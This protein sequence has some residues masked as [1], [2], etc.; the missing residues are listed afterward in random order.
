MIIRTV[1]WVVLG[2]IGV[3]LAG[4]AIFGTDLPSYVYSSAKSVRTAVKD[5]VPVE[6]ELTR[7]RDLL[8][9]IIPEMQAN[10][11]LIAQQEVEIA[12]LKQDI[13][14][15]QKSL[16]E[17]QMRVA[18]LRDCLATSQVSFS[19]G[20]LDYSRDQ[21][22]EDLARKFDHYKEAE[23]IL[24]GKQRLLQNREKALMGGMQAIERTRAQKSLLESKIEALQGQYRL[25]QAASV[26]SKVTVDNSKLAQTEKV[27]AQ[28]KKQLDVAERVLAHEARFTESIPVDGI[29]EK[30]LMMAVD[31]HFNTGKTAAKTEQPATPESPVSV[32]QSPAS[33]IR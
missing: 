11:R 14:Q 23:V 21:L 7:A 18:K 8:N 26:G 16:A 24:T 13:G 17:E 22:R 1:K 25:V 3:A 27:I 29:N 15:S 2:G 9:D 12:S 33:C 20:H 4:G 5:S 10:I 30:D 32:S 19:F 28:I 31:E 6:F